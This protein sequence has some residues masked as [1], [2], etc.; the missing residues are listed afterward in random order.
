MMLKGKMVLA[1]FRAGAGRFIAHQWP[2][3]DPDPGDGAHQSAAGRGNQNRT[4]QSAVS[5]RIE[6]SIRTIVGILKLPRHL[7]R[8]GWL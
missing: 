5:L 4:L 7:W 3:L 2:G 6:G 1:F 8:G